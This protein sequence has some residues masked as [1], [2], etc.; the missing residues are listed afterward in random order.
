MPRSAIAQ[1]VDRLEERPGRRPPR[2]ARSCR[3][4]D[5][6]EGAIAQDV[7]RL[8]AAGL[9]EPPDRG[10]P[11]PPTVETRKFSRYQL[12]ADPPNITTR[13]ENSRNYC[14]L[15]SQRADVIFQTWPGDPDRGNE[16]TPNEETRR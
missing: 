12:S 11:N 15:D 7:D 10:N 14:R 5:H 1:D 16:L 13:G 3:G 9:P 8:G 6:A 4:R 2:G